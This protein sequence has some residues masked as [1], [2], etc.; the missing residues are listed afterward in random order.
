MRIINEKL[1][2]ELAHNS[3]QK[4]AGNIGVTPGLAVDQH[5]PREQREDKKQ[6][7]EKAH[8]VDQRIDEHRLCDARIEHVDGDYEHNTGQDTSLELSQIG[9]AACYA[10]QVGRELLVQEKV[11]KASGIVIARHH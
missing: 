11:N 9:R 4:Q 8:R 3:N 1:L 2:H 7:H 5:Q 10:M 6:R